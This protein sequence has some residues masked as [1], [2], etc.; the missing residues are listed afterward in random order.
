MLISSIGIAERA[1]KQ[2]PAY[3]SIVE[4]KEFMELNSVNQFRVVLSLAAAFLSVNESAL[5][6]TDFFTTWS[7]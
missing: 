5:K 1:E 4:N 3:K 6:A 2:F 7:A